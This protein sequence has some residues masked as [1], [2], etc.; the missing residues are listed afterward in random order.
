VPDAGEEGRVVGNYCLMDYGYEVSVLQ[1][2]KSEDV[3]FYNNV[4]ARK[5]TELYN[6][7]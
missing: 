4:N 6:E 2:E 7:T 1:D 3:W 5:T